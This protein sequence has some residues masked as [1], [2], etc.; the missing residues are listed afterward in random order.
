MLRGANVSV[1]V[2][3]TAITLREAILNLLVP[4]A[5]PETALPGWAYRTRTGE[6][7]RAL[8]DW[9]CVTI[10]PEVGAVWWRRPFARQL[11]EAH[12]QLGRDFG[13][14]L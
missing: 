11:H 5:V 2:R 9:I 8:L 1:R 14:D 7:V 12:L 6:S 3:L 4:D 10:R 13:S